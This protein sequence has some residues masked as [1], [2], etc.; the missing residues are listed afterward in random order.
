VHATGQHLAAGKTNDG[1][2]GNALGWFGAL[3]SAAVRPAPALSLPALCLLA[4]AMAMVATRHARRRAAH[5]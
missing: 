2:T 4:L 3:V 1:G 5:K